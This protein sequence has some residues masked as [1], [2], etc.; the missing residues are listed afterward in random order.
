M[1]TPIDNVA[2]AEERI[3]VDIAIKKHKNK[4][5][6]EQSKRERD[7]IREFIKIKYPS[8]L[9]EVKHKNL[10]RDGVKIIP[11]CCCK[12]SSWKIFPFDFIGLNGRDYG[13]NKC[14]LCT[15]ADTR[16]SKKYQDSNRIKCECGICYIGAD[17]S[18]AKHMISKQH[19][20]RVSEMIKGVR[21]TKG[22]LIKLCS[23]YSIPYYKRLNF[24]QMLD[25]LRPKMEIDKETNIRD[26]LKC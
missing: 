16:V 26:M 21:Y 20:D 2:I 6:R 23:Y 25:V 14:K 4:I 24:R 9:D 17:N 8:G 12:C 10:I 7:K 11:I 19:I 13:T 22:E 18:I 5:R 15:Y 3:R 1:I